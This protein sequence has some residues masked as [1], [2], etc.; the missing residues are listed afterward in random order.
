MGGRGSV[1]RSLGRSSLILWR[2]L[3]GSELLLQPSLKPSNLFF[4][5]VREIRE[6]Y[7]SS[8]TDEHS[9][10]EEYSR[11]RPPVARK[12][13]GNLP[14]DSIKILKKWL[15]DHRYNA[16]PSDAEKVTLAREANLTVLQVRSITTNSWDFSL[17]IRFAF[18]LIRSAIGS[19]TPDEG[20][21]PTWFAAK[22]TTLIATRSAAEAKRC[23]N[24]VR[25]RTGKSRARPRSRPRRRSCNRSTASGSRPACRPRTRTAPKVLPCI[26]PPTTPTSITTATILRC[27]VTRTAPARVPAVT[28]SWC[29]RPRDPG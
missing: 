18:W 13:R 1:P 4:S 15:Y 27:L 16:Y 26:G 14:K 7:P 2:L 3:L 12:R 17:L 21:C 10:S 8:S 20:S 11:P 28:G 5:A 29:R 25:S 22:A 9:S 19:S 23:P 6:R 24:W